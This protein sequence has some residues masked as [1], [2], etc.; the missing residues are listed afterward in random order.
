MTIRVLLVDDHRLVREALRDALQ[1]LPDIE[2]VAEAGDGRT[3]IEQS[4]ALRPDVAVIDI[5]LPDLNGM[6][7]AAR[8]HDADAN[9]RIV[10]LSAYTDKRFVTEMLRSGASAYVI[11]ASA[12]TE[13]VRAIHAVMEGQNYFCPEI[14]GALVAEVRGSRP[15]REMPHLARREREV[16]RMIAQGKRSQAIGDELHISVSTV[17]VHRR[18]IMRKLGLHTIADLTKYAIREGIASL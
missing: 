6:E 7:L 15:E 5:G 9:I 14:A 8:L 11:K 10:A 4:R 3:A 18:N 1:K 16:L 13:L 12:G 2:V 17:E